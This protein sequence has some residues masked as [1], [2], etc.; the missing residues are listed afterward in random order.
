MNKAKI[1][2]MAGQGLLIALIVVLQSVSGMI[3][4]IGGFSISLVLIPIVLGAALYGPAGGALL[5]AAFGVI[6]II[7]CITGADVG[8]QMV[9]Q[10]N[11]ILCIAVV[12]GKGILAGLASGFVYSLLKEKNSYIAMLLAAAVCPMVNTGFFVACMLTFFRDVLSAW[13]GGG[14][15]MAYVLSGLMLCN[16]LPELII[17]VVF[18][19]A[20]QRILHTVKQ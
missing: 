20:G 1:K 11:P 9:F 3:P 16:F 17:N 4:P 6:V 10:A 14:D 7:N 5:G 15:I 12:M 19:P 2:R 18:S 13:A 8:G